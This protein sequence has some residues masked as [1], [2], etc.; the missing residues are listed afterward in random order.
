[1]AADDRQAL[2]AFLVGLGASEED[3][4]QYAAELPGLASVLALRLGRPTLTLADMAARSGVPVE[5][6]TQRWRAAGFPD[7]GPGVPVASEVEAEVFTMLD[8][9]EK[10]FGRDAVLQLTR[11]MG[12]ATA[13]IADA[14]V[15]AFL[16]N[17]ELPQLGGEQVDLAVAKANAEA[18]TLLPI[19][20]RGIEVLLRRHLLAARRSLVSV[21]RQAGVEVQ[22]LAVGFV[23][24]VGSTAL[25][26]RLSTAALGTALG[27]FEAI[28]TDTVTDLG[29]RVVKLI[30]DEV[31]YSV[32]DPV[33][34]CRVALALTDALRAHPVLPPVRGGIA[35]GAVMLRD[36]D[37]FGRIVNLAARAVKLARPGHVVVSSDVRT[38]V[39]GSLACAA[40][41]PARVKGFDGEIELFELSG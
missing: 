40:L 7:P 34:A 26:Q 9:A 18:V 28:V 14:A 20:F 1:M 33:V 29:A 37:C 24:L 39:Q 31:M 38:A 32:A 4:A 12:L 13:R 17:L 25:G 5:V 22:Q 11:V 19:L 6:V 8:A 16:V 27:E 35:S 36:G 15:S 2:I 23:D 3:L 21:D 41:P 30:G 10:L